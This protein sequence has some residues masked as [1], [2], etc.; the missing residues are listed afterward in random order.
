M[1]HL[2]TY[3]SPDMSISAKRCVES[4]RRYGVDKVWT[5]TRAAIEQTEFYEQNREILDVPRGNG[6]W[7]WK[8][9]IILETLKRCNA[10]D[11]VIYA[12]AGVEFIAPISHVTKQMGDIWLFGN[13]YK[14]EHWAKRDIMKH[15]GTW[16]KGNQCQASVILAKP[17][18]RKFIEEWLSYCCIKQL[19]DDS[20]SVTQNH[21]EF[22]DNRHDQAILTCVAHKWQV[23]LNWWPAIYN[24]GAFTY[25]S[26]GYTKPYPPLFHHHRKRNHEYA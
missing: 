11:I 17:G 6:L 1:I 2:V 13:M 10:E 21:P 15:I 5:W 12:D 23:P 14:H 4:G 19:I 9:Y 3:H 16:P 8:P 7:A 18:A 22:R 20:P 26:E 24:S 25:S